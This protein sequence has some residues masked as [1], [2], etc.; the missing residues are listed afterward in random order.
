MAKVGIITFLHNENYGSSLQAYALQRA[1]RE[2]GH[3][4]EHID[5]MP[6]RKEKIRNLLCS[7]N[8]LKLIA[9]GLRKRSVRSAQ[10]GARE[11]SGAIPAFYR[12]RMKLGPVCRNRA[13]LRNQAEKYDI[14]VCGSDQIWNPVWLNPAY[15][16]TFAPEG[17]RKVAY[18]ASLGIRTMPAARK[19]RKIRKWTEG[20]SAIS[21][22]EEEG[23]ELLE[24]MTGLKADVMPDPVCLLSREEWEEVAVPCGDGP[25]LLCYFI[26]ENESYWEKVRKLSAESGLPVRVIPVTAE[27]Y[28]SGYELLDD[29]GPE[30]FLGAIRNASLFCTDSFHGLAFGTIF[31]TKTEVIRRYREDD[32]ESKNSRVDHFLRLRDEKGPDRIR[33]EGREWLARQLKA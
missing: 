33:E 15:F 30:R 29:I 11:K 19:V 10:Q 21:V 24:K 13:E 31:G 8:D 2:A 23:A 1:V 16:L 9:E 14:L 26:G 25:Y 5:Y 6:D 18:A 32:P 27:S 20:F 12:E 22:R 7:G 28:A 17:I 3:D 4:C